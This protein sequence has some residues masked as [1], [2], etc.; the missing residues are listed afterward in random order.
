[1]NLIEQLERL[2]ALYTANAITADEF[3][4]AKAKLLGNEPVAD[5]KPTAVNTVPNP[6]TRL[7]RSQYDR[8]F[9]GVC[10][11][12]AASTDVPAWAWRV[13]FVLLALLHGLGL[14]L[15]ILLWIFMPLASVAIAKPAAAVAPDCTST[16]TPNRHPAAKLKRHRLTFPS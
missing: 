9:G 5:S 15:Y 8:W 2:N 3:A 1:M 7:G 12:L 6:M 14:L 11:G 16:D 4:K 10:G 13:L